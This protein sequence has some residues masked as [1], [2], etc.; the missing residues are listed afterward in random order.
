MNTNLDILRGSLEKNNL[1]ALCEQTFSSSAIGDKLRDELDVFLIEL[2]AKFTRDE[3]IKLVDRSWYGLVIPVKY[4]GILLKYP[5]LAQLNGD[6]YES[7]DKC[8]AYI[9]ELFEDAFE[10]IDIDVDYSIYGKYL[11]TLPLT[12]DH[13][14]IIMKHLPEPIARPSLDAIK[15]EAVLKDVLSLLDT[16]PNMF[17]GYLPV[18]IT[19]DIIRRVI[20]VNLNAI[21]S[22]LDAF[23]VMPTSHVEVKEKLLQVVDNIIDNT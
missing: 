3:L 6:A 9:A 16:M 12:A 19:T 4:P 13:V 5:K 18:G 7:A 11:D 1:N 17:A 2:S 21:R 15:T 23:E 10:D 22:Y 8:F 20:T 14:A